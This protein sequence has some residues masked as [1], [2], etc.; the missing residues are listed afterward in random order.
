[1][2]R[3]L[4]SA[5]LPESVVQLLRTAAPAALQS[6]SL[7]TQVKGEGKGQGHSLNWVDWRATHLGPLGFSLPTSS[8]LF[9]SQI[10]LIF[11]FLALFLGIS[12]GIWELYI[13]LKGTVG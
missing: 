1:M 3:V 10:V 5:L 9:T 6:P 8:Q 12:P 13:W 7:K 11:F 4:P 2:V